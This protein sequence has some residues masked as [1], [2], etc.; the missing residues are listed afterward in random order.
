MSKYQHGRQQ[1]GAG[2]PWPPWIFI[3]GADLVDRG[4]I[5]LFFGLFCYFRS[6]F[7]GPPWKRLNSAI[8]RVFLLFFGFPVAPSTPEIFFPTPLN[9]KF[10]VQGSCTLQNFYISKF[11]PVSR[12]RPIDNFKTNMKF[13]GIICQ[14][15]KQ[16]IQR[17]LLRRI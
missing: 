9:T 16:Q 1:R 17:Q 13:N 8:F 14:H 4:L 2:C 6:F 15:F 7:V 3:Y 11:N 12:A 5:V 10:Q